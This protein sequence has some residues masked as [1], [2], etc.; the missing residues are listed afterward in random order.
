MNLG[1]E[2]PSSFVSIHM[3]M[4]GLAFVGRPDPDYTTTFEAY[5]FGPSN[6]KSNMHDVFVYMYL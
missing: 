4:F 5:I 3:Y 6:N 1:I 2:S